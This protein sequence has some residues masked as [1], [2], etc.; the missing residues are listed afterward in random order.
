MGY[1]LL[2]PD[3]KYLVC[4]NDN[5]WHLFS[6]KLEYNC[7][8]KKWYIETDK[9]AKCKNVYSM[10]DYSFDNLEKHPF[11]YGLFCHFK[12]VGNHIFGFGDYYTDKYNS[13]YFSEN[14]NIIRMISSILGKAVCKDCVDALY[15]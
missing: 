3:K 4:N 7:L 1:I 5:H 14:E 15:L 8:D 11:N 12:Y 13:F 6:S 9:E 2:P 10:R